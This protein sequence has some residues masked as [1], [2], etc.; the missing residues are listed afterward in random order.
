MRMELVDDAAAGVQTVMRSVVG[1]QRF[2]HAAFHLIDDGVP[3]GVQ[4]VLQIGV[5]DNLHRVRE[6][7]LRLILDGRSG[8]HLW[9]GLSV[10]EEHVQ[11]NPG[12]ECGLTVLT[13][14]LHIRI[15]E[16][17]GAVGLHPSVDVP[18]DE[19][20]PRLQPETLPC[21]LSLGVF[22]FLDK[23]D[24]LDCRLPIEIP[25]LVHSDRQI[26]VIPLDGKLHQ[27]AADDAA[28]ADILCV[29]LGLILLLTHCSSMVS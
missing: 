24:G 11:S 20:L 22:E 5:L 4:I 9:P 10:S 19:L 29:L 7:D 17:P 21:P 13:R 6:A 28:I 26:V 3:V 1:G 25:T 14:N 27:L 2:H 16:P 15:A 18:D 8:I 23:A 12:R